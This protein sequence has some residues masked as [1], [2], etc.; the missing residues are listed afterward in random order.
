MQRP[1]G[2]SERILNWPERWDSGG[3]RMKVGKEGERRRKEK[4]RRQA[5]WGPHQHVLCGKLV[6][7]F[8]VL[9]LGNSEQALGIT[10]IAAGW[11]VRFPLG[12]V[13]L[14]TRWKIS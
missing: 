13:I 1:G 2:K 12:R 6:N 14:A 4:R 7:K 8:F 9:F 5:H 11:E 3:R 10:G